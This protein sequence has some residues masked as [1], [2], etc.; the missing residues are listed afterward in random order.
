MLAYPSSLPC[1]SRIEGHS[2]TAFAGLVRTPMES[3][4]ARQRRAHHVL[5]HRISLVFIISQEVYGDWLAWVNANAY[6]QWIALQLPGFLA[7]RAGTNTAAVPVRFVSDVSAELIPVHRL[8][9]WRCSVQ[10]EWLPSTADLVPT[11]FGPW[12]LADLSIQDA[13]YTSDWINAGTP[14]A[15]S[16]AWVNAGSVLA[17]SAYI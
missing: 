7:A 10:A 14:S 17:P 5:P 9:Y 6:D 8:W 13:T 3:G 2:A 4:N 11:P 1:V 12:V 16:P 15:P